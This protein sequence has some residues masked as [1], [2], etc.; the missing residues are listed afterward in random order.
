[1]YNSNRIT[2]F[3]KKHKEEKEIG[4]FK[5]FIEKRFGCYDSAVDTAS[6]DAGTAPTNITTPED[7]PISDTVANRNFVSRFCRVN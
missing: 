6:A 3:S 1:M 2:R 4:E 5:D 7:T